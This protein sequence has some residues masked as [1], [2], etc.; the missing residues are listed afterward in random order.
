MSIA[1]QLI[2]VKPEAKPAAQQE[3]VEQR[4]L[5]ARELID[6]VAASEFLP[7][8]EVTHDT[9]GV[10]KPTDGSQ[11]ETGNVTKKKG[12]KGDMA[13]GKSTP[14]QVASAPSGGDPVKYGKS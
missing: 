4:P 8:G 12:E 7:E 1:Q 14:G 6:A 2:G 3:T 5:T 9:T 11:P 10:G 13:K